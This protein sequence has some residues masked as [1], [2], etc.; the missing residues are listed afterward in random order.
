MAAIA[1]RTRHHM[2]RQASKPPRRQRL[3]CRRLLHD[4]PVWGPIAVK[5]AIRTLMVT[6]SAGG[7]L[8]TA[9]LSATCTFWP[10]GAWQVSHEPRAGT[11][12]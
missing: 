11:E 6:S 5:P 12:G 7:G 1:F 10:P 4:A 9:R 3:R 2:P 8:E